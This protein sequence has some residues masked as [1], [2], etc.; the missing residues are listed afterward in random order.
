MEIGVRPDV[1][2]LDGAIGGSAIGLAQWLVLRQRLKLARWW[3]LV[4][5]VSWGLIGSSSLG[6]IGWVAPRTLLLKLRV[7]VGILDGTLVGTLIGI[8]QWFVIRQQVKSASVWIL[9]NAIGWGIGLALGWTVGGL[10]RLATHTFLSELIGLA[11]A[12]II[13]AAITGVTLVLLLDVTV[14][15]KLLD[16]QEKTVP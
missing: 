11:V 2:A 8:G 15:E 3:I 13:V 14:R 6:A 9:A 16:N 4:S 12:W 10:L 5:L 1:K 7:T